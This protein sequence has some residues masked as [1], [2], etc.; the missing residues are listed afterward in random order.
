M[1]DR[2]FKTKMKIIFL[3]STLSGALPV[4]RRPHCHAC[5]NGMC[6]SRSTVFTAHKFSGQL[7]VDR[8]ANI[9]Y[10]HY[11]TNRSI[12]HTGSF[13]LNDIKFKVLPKIGFTFGRA[14]DQST[15]EVFMSGTVGIHKYN[16]K[17]NTVKSI[18]LTD[19]TIWHLQYKDKIY[20]SEFKSKGIFTYEKNKIKSIKALSNFHVD[21]FVIDKQNDIYFLSDSMIYRLKNGT[22]TADFFIDEIFSLA[23]DKKGDVH[24]IQPGSRTVYILDYS[25]DS[26]TEL[27]AIGKGTPF[28]VV[29]DAD[30]NMIYHDVD[31]E[32]LYY[33]MPNYSLCT[34]TT[35]G[36]GKNVKKFVSMRN[37]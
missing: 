18:G 7:A 26:L 37:E 32:K 22:K 17:T 35:R 30:N 3:L 34:V 16:P 9:L 8:T 6:H 28:S 1:A 25:K 12:D 11:Q 27:G 5:F 19:K 21:D 33:L 14:V 20:Y 24:F 4:R 23:T 2:K 29:F 36:K 31:D 13:D 15:R 10:F